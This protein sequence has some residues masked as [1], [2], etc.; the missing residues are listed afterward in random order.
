MVDVRGHWNDHQ[1]SRR[2]A[3]R[4]LISNLECIVWSAKLDNC[5]FFATDRHFGVQL[6]QKSLKHLIEWPEQDLKALV[7]KYTEKVDQQRCGFHQIENWEG[8]CLYKHNARNSPL[9]TQTPLPDCPLSQLE[10]WRPSQRER[11]G[12][13]RTMT[14]P[15]LSCYVCSRDGKMPPH[16]LFNLLRNRRS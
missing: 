8:N 9:H 5:G 4:Y 14:L 2:I 6:F 15:A 7:S 3:F 10:R 11:S 12:A 13:E 16:D 1:L